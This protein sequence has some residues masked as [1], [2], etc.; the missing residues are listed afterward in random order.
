[1]IALFIFECSIFVIMLLIYSILVYAEF[2]WRVLLSTVK[3][4]KQLK[5][6][7]ER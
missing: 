3:E 4:L 1:M 6:V 2:Y 5:E 7:V